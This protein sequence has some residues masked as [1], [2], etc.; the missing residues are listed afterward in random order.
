MLKTCTLFEG[1]CA[2]QALFLF[3]VQLDGA[4]LS[5]ISDPNTEFLCFC[6]F[7]GDGK[8]SGC[9]SVVCVDVSI[10]MDKV[11]E[12]CVFHHS[13]FVFRTDSYVLESCWDSMLKVLCSGLALSS[14]GLL[15]RPSLLI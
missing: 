5:Q 1:G 7:A 9:C 6:V 14:K 10:V 11:Q 15:L 12:K 13:F 8:S 4:S 3:I 2:Y